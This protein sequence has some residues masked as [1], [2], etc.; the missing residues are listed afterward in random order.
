MTTE[1]LSDIDREILSRFRRDTLCGK[2]GG[3]IERNRLTTCWKC[4]IIPHI[5]T[6][7]DW[8]DTA[9]MNMAYQMGIKRK[10]EPVRQSTP[11]QPKEQ[12]KEPAAKTKRKPAA[13]TKR[14]T[15]K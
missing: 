8:I 9:S 13:K 7:L 6:Q 1:T 11:E 4:D 14:N 12:P 15:K 5:R 2:C 3:P 10:P